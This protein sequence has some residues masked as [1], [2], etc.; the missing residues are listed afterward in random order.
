MTITEMEELVRFV[1]RKYG[2]SRAT[3]KL[4]ALEEEKFKRFLIGEDCFQHLGD[5]EE[6]LKII[7]ERGKAEYGFSPDLESKLEYM[8]AQ[9]LGIDNKSLIKVWLS[10]HEENKQKPLYSRLLAPYL[11]VFFEYVSEL[12]NYD[13]L[14]IYNPQRLAKSF[15]EKKIAMAIIEETLHY[16]YKRGKNVPIE[17]AEVVRLS[18]KILK[19][20]ERRN[21]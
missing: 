2:L 5:T 12:L 6:E 10:T 17:H 13:F 14:I 18:K 1:L 9:C 16:C 19:E 15:S 7:E 8:Y 11:D 21:N 20:Y 4:F 3:F